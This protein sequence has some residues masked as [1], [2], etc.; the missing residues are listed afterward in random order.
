MSAED[1]IIRFI[2]NEEKLQNDKINSEL[3]SGDKEKETEFIF[4][5]EYGRWMIESKKK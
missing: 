1:T 3:S 5:F 4:E 2:E